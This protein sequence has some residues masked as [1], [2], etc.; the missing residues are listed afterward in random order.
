MNTESCQQLMQIIKYPT[1]LIEICDKSLSDVDISNV[2][3][4][5]RVYCSIPHTPLRLEKLLFYAFKTVPLQDTLEDI[6]RHISIVSKYCMCIFSTASIS[7]KRD[8]KETNSAFSE[9]QL[10]LLV[11]TQHAALDEWEQLIEDMLLNYDTIDQ[12]DII[13][14]IR[15]TV[16]LTKLTVLEYL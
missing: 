6:Y 8:N 10:I 5:Y 3:S 12:I 16:K 1:F 11:T 13:E 4:K 7:H 15:W 9:E 14:K 2:D